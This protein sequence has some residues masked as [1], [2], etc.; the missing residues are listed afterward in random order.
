MPIPPFCFSAPARHRLCASFS[1][2][3][4]TSHRTNTIA[5]LR[6]TSRRPRYDVRP[7]LLILERQ[8]SLVKFRSFATRA[9]RHKSSFC[10]GPAS[11][12]RP[13]PCV[14]KYKLHCART[15]ASEIYP[16]MPRRAPLGGRLAVATPAATTFAADPGRESNTTE[17]CFAAR[18]F[19][20]GSPIEPPPM[21]AKDAFLGYL[22][23][24]GAS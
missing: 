19:T 16:P 15:C 10:A 12:H 9:T 18:T 1:S 14:P 4:Y 23:V 21:T 5:T 11:Y 24:R 17:T 13:G 20:M 8:S 6:A 3:P 22:H 7:L 2:T